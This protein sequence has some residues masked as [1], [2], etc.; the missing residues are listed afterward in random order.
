LCA[1]H[2]RYFGPKTITYLDPRSLAYLSLN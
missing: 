2:L 1:N